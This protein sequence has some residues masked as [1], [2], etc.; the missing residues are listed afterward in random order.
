MIHID[1]ATGGLII[2]IGSQTVRLD[3]TDV[4]DLA[5]LAAHPD[6]TA[7]GQ[8]TY[9]VVEGSTVRT[10]LAHRHG[11]TITLAIGLDGT[12]EAAR[13]TADNLTRT[14]RDVTAAGAR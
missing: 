8:A 4:R 9:T 14:M 11:Q 3:P 5:A 12:Y 1:P 2:S 10:V 6:G 13:T 7:W